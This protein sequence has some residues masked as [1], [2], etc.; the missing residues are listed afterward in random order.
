MIIKNLN[1]F[2]QKSYK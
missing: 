1:T 2:M